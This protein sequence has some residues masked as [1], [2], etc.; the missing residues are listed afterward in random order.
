MNK[1][2]DHLWI[3]VLVLGFLYDFLFWDQLT[4]VNYILFILALLFGAA[5]LFLQAEIR[6]AR[7]SLWLLF[8]IVMFSA[9]TFVHQEPLTKGLAFTFSILSLFLLVVSYIGGRWPEYSLADYIQRSIIL[10]IS[11]V[12]GGYVF[13]SQ[14]Q[15]ERKESNAPSRITFIW[16]ILRGLLIAIPFIVLFSALFSSADLVF[17]QKLTD[18]LDRFETNDIWE[19][20]QRLIIILFIAY[21]LAG[22][23]LHAA[24]KSKEEKLFREGKYVLKP[25]LGITETAVVLGY[26]AILF[27]IFVGIQFRYFFGGEVNIG[28]EGYTYSQYARRGFNELIWVAFFSLIMLLGLGEVT[29][30]EASIERRIFSGL[31]IV[32]VSLVMVIL[33]SAYQRIMLGIG[34]HGFSRLRLY[35]RIFLVWLGLLFIAVVVLEILRK[36]NFIT[37]AALLASFGFAISLSMISVDAATVRHNLP[38]ALHGVNINIEHIS[39]LSTDAVPP[40]VEEFQNLEYS[41]FHHQQI[42]AIIVCYMHY[43][44]YEG[45]NANDW[46]S[47]N[48]SRWRAKRAIESIQGQLQEY[49]IN[50]ERSFA[51]VRTPA[52]RYYKCGFSEYELEWR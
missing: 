18:F 48:L 7:N 37:F 34:W 10:G 26:V 40:L 9:L 47:F 32:I 30:R 16:A 14:V 13:A 29:K 3:V 15:K 44:S 21:L 35:P 4:G 49:G 1:K 27:A 41:E 36:E 43:Q 45:K 12:T 38:R 39:T 28:V 42:G 17:D 19:Y 46:R 6:P 11:A 51:R 24:T 5:I 20:I 33:V 52:G 2:P 25:F 23:F 50:T 8:P 22:T 31:S